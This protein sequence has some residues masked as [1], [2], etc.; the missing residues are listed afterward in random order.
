MNVR[1]RVNAVRGTACLGVALGVQGIPAAAQDFVLETGGTEA[2][3]TDS[4]LFQAVSGPNV[5]LRFD[6]GMATAEGPL[7]GSFLDSVTFSLEGASSGIT[8]IFATE[9]GSG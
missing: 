5:F 9:D 8:T 6:F 1:M 3:V 7:A 4:H 2:L